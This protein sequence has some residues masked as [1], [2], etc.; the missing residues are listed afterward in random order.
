M[1]YVPHVD[2]AF[3]S[4]EHIMRDVEYGWFI[5]YLHSNGASMIFVL[6]YLHIAKGLYFRSY[7]SSRVYL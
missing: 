2:L 4:V 3:A 1:H 7:S 6:L 5:R